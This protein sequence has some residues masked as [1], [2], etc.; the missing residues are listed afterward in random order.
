MRKVLLSLLFIGVGSFFLWSPKGK[1]IKVTPFV[2]VLPE[3]RPFAGLSFA[4]E[5]EEKGYTFEWTLM[6]ALPKKREYLKRLAFYLNNRNTEKII[7]NNLTPPFSKAKLKT[8]PKEKLV[9]IHW[10]PPSVFLHQYKQDALDLFGTVLTFC[11]DLVDNKKYFKIHY[12]DLLPYQDNLPPFHERKLICMVN[13]NQKIN[14]FEK[15][16]YSFRREAVQF[17]EEKPQ[18]TFDLFGKGWDGFKNNCG[19]V[20]SYLKEVTDGYYD[21]K[22]DLLKRYKFNLCFENCAVNGYITE[23]IFHPFAVGTIPVYLGAP[24]IE[25]YIPKG[26]YIDF[27]DFS[28]F[29]EL[30]TYLENMAEEEFLTYQKNIQAFLKSPAAYPFT[31]AAYDEALSNA[32]QL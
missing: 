15:E 2:H 13:G 12:P 31:S 24:N 22:L 14:D 7:F 3:G 1:V 29:E 9:L 16:L 5:M 21:N 6:N 23:K 25:S 17:F 28:G 10:E 8:I 20:E 26:C 18:G 30:L 32:L 19:T 4:K 11:D 27:R